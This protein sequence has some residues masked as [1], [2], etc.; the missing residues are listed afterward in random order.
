MTLAA[1]IRK[2]GAGKAANDNSA[3]VANGGQTRGEALAGLAV[4]A[5]ASLT[6][7]KT[8][9]ALRHGLTLADLRDAAG[10]DWPEVQ[11]NP[12]LLE[13]LAHAVSVRR[14]RERGEVPPGYTST[15]ICAHCGP[16]PIFEGVPERV[17]GCPWCFNRAAGRPMPSTCRS[18]H[19]VVK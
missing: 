9:T 4:L 15:T 17:L 7:P 8:A 5:L 18:D 16:V 13:T 10:P 2:R 11:V 19:G 1:L 6:S 14:M 12:V 3:K